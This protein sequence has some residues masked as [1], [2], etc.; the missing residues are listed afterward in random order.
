MDAFFGTKPGVV[1]V[2]QGVLEALPVTVTLARDDGTMI[3]DRAETWKAILTGFDLAGMGAVSSGLTM[4]QKIYVT[5]VGGE[6][7]G[8]AR[9]SGVWFSAV[10]PTE[11]T[12]TGVDGIMALYEGL[13]FSTNGRACRIAIA[14]N[15]VLTGIMK[16]FVLRMIDPGSGLGEFA[17][18]FD[19]FPRGILPDLDAPFTISTLASQALTAVRQTALAGA[20]LW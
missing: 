8:R 6:H 18:D 4:R 16:S 11:G 3:F 19:W 2:L 13:R 12:G 10:C 14:R 20:S 5:T 9:L 17:F 1:G 7:P 15:T